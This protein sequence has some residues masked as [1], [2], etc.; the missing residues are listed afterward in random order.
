MHP[1]ALSVALCALGY[2]AVALI[3]LPN[4]TSTQA[5]DAAQDEEHL[6]AATERAAPR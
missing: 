2:A 6:A 1:I 4:S 5:N 3:Q